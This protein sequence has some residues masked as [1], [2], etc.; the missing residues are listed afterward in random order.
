MDKTSTNFF[1]PTTPKEAQQAA[2]YVEAPRIRIVTEM[3]ERVARA[4]VRVGASH[5]CGADEIEEVIEISWRNCI[6]IA[7]A[8][9]AAI[10]E[11]TEAM[12]NAAYDYG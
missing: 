4:I 10:R 9:I 1:G 6:D 11:P 12:V 7:L 8:A 5:A 3:V 2:G